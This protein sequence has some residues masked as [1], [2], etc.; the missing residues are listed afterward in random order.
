MKTIVLTLIV[1]L[2]SVAGYS[3]E[4][5]PGT[6]ITLEAPEGFTKATQFPGFMMESTGASILV[7]EV[8]GP[9][10]EITEGFK[11]KEALAARGMVLLES[12]EVRIASGTALLLQVGQIVEEAAYL[13][14]ILVFGNEKE[15]VMITATLPE[16]VA[17]QLSAAAKKSLLTTRW[18]TAAK[19]DFFEGLTFRVKELGGLKIANKVGN[20][21]IM[22]NN[23]VFPQRDLRDPVVVVGASLTES[24]TKPG[25]TMAYARAR[26]AQTKEL[27]ESTVTAETAITINGMEAIVLEVDAKEK[28][29]GQ[30]L[31]VL[32][33][34]IFAPKGYYIFQGFVERAQKDTYASDFAA[35]LM[36]FRQL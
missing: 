33:G 22:T 15:T 19:V 2:S 24:F 20:T 17:D 16:Q 30:D 29:S 34:L 5:I 27:R 8:P 13:K 25:D 6:K 36:S 3:A 10:S 28:E 7:S 26:L 9:F 11:S 12:S 4:R 32:H 1:V 35:I 14:W 21:I 23:G 18:D 31:Y